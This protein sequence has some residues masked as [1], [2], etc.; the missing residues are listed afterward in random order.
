VVKEVNTKKIYW[1]CRWT[2]GEVCKIFDVETYNA[3]IEKASIK[4]DTNKM[5]SFLVSGQRNQAFD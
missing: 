1:V 5:T 2:S 4:I 3:R